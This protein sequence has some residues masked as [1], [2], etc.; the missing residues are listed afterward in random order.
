MAFECKKSLK[1]KINNSETTIT[2]YFSFF[3]FFFFSVDYCSPMEVKS[4]FGNCFSRIVFLFR[5]KKMG[6][7][8]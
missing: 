8:V 2:S 5:Q 7:H 1:D 4:L 6:K 3:F